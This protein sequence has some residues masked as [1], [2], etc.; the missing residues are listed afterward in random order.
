VSRQDAATNPADPTPV[1]KLVLDPEATLPLSLALTSM[2]P[3]SRHLLI[4][5]GSEMGLSLSETRT[6]AAS[7]F[8]PARLGLYILRAVTAA[9]AAAAVVTAYR[10]R[11]THANIAESSS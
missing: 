8:R 1:Q 3:A 5:C 4:L 10:D 6:L 2:P 9:V 7:G 11:S